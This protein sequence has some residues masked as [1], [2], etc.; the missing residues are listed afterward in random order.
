MKR[1]RLQRLLI[2][3][4]FIQFQVIG[5]PRNLSTRQKLVMRKSREKSWLASKSTSHPLNITRA[6]QQTRDIHS[7]IDQ[8][9][10][11]LINIFERKGWNTCTSG[12][13]F[14]SIATSF[15]GGTIVRSCNFCYQFLFHLSLHWRRLLERA[16]PIRPPTGRNRTAFAAF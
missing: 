8:V 9:S 1:K 12:L 5:A 4:S 6:L 16:P 13:D 10:P 2:I 15:S 11:I 3:S 14:G 7:T